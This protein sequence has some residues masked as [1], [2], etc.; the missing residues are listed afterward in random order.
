MERVAQIG[1]E[2]LTF[3]YNEKDSSE[4]GVYSIT[5]GNRYKR[6]IEP[7]FEDSVLNVPGYDGEY[8]YGTNITKQTFALS[9]FAHHLTL[10]EYDRMRVWLHPRTVGKL[11]LPDHPYK[12][13]IVK[14]EEISELSLLALTEG[15]VTGEGRGFPGVFDQVVYTGNFEVM[16]RTIGSAYAY[17]FQYFRDDLLYDNDFYYD[18]GLL[19]KDMTPALI[20]DISTN[21]D[22]ERLKI[23]NPGTVEAKPTI[24]IDLGA[25]AL[26]DNSFIKFQNTSTGTT[27]F[28]NVSGLKDEVTLSFMDS[29]IV[30]SDSIV[31]HGRVLGTNL[32]IAPKRDILYIPETHVVINPDGTETV[33]N[34]IYIDDNVAYIDPQFLKVDNSMV[35][36]FLNIFYNGGAEILSVNTT[37]NTLALDTTINGGE[38][39]YDI[40]PAVG[41]VPAGFACNYVECDNVMPVEDG[42]DGD[43]IVV[44]LQWYIWLYGEWKK[45]NLFSEKSDFYDEE[46]EYETKYILLGATILDLDKIYVTTGDEVSFIWQSETIEGATMPNIKLDFIILPRYL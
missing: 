3:K 16:F 35:G 20:Y 1:E 36:K 21:T 33:F 4:M 38:G 34:T 45:T 15:Q 24:N 41:E 14:P 39:T 27:S 11:V 5:E 32:S 6:S 28:V 12:Y 31:H 40:L 9:C 8:Y 2:Y 37:E 10:P 30:D 7:E 13:Y 17:G 25:T 23:Y 26:D 22:E 42:N 18:S 29:T 43:V 19:Y 46:E 44:N